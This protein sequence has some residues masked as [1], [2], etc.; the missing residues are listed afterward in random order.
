M[1]E[2]NQI[3]INKLKWEVG[4]LGSWSWKAETTKGS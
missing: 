1:Q 4:E 3:S 2:E